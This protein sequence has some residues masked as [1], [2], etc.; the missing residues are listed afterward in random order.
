MDQDAY[1][2]GVRMV[3][4]DLLKELTWA[5]IGTAVLVL[6]LTVV[7]SSP[8]VTPVTIRSWAQAD[9]VDF[10]T[11]ATLEL[12][13]QSPSSQYGPPYN[14]GSNSVQSL[15]F[16]KPQ[17]WAGVH[18]SVDSAQEFVIQ[19]LQDASVGNPSLATALATFK[20]ADDKQRTSWLD[21]YS[22][23]LPEASV[24]NGEVTVVQGDYGPLPE[25]MA[26]LLAVA[27]SGGLD[28]LLLSSGHF[29]QTDFTR[30]LLFM[31]DGGYLAG[32]AKQQ[33]LLGTQWG[34]MNETGSYPG[35]AWLWLYTALYQVPPYNSS[36]SADLL[37]VLTIGVLTL[38]LAAIPFIPGLRDIP[39]LVPVYR[40]IW[41]RHYATKESAVPAPR[42]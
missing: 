26:G 32:L 42:G 31:S 4:Y 2:R 11:T 35:Q 25:M 1:Y 33:H 22:K 34:V 18:L 15:G 10:V 29:Y 17:S 14:D 24:Q 12:Q 6:V 28:G 20:S 40:V 27:R 5:M 8:D 36:S 3:P 21:A 41:R 37:V 19:P 13:G 16:I 39:R 38:L 30:P 23:A 9:P 7:L